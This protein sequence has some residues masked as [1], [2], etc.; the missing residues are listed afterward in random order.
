MFRR[1]H[2][3]PLTRRLREFFW[4]SIGFRRST[5]Y[6]MHRIGR[7]PGTPTSIAV[8]FACGVAIAFTPFVGFHLA[9]AALIAWAVRGSPLAAAIG[10][11]VGNPWTIPL[12]LI[13]IYHLGAWILG[14]QSHHHLPHHVGFS[15]MARHPFQVLLPMTVGSVPVA[16][17]AWIVSFFTARLLVAGYHRR[18]HLR[19]ST[20]AA[21]RR[22]GNKEE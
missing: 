14:A 16:I 5:R 9:I 15:Y 8:G 1:R 17:A 6:L 22:R 7:M 20:P 12:I 18:R 19:R 3:Q 13:G 21:R 10:T 11:L 2:K 4:P